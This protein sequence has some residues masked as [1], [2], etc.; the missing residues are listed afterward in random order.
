[1]VLHDGQYVNCHVRESGESC[2]L[3]LLGQALERDE[4]LTI[5]PCH[6]HHL[7]MKSW[8]LREYTCHLSDEMVGSN[9]AY[10][11]IQLVEAVD[12]RFCGAPAGII[13]LRQDK[14]HPVTPSQLHFFQ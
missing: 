3:A 8:V 5:Q 13:L 4:E 10:H 6:L 1:M 2:S 11:V 7:C 9:T 12:H 14:R